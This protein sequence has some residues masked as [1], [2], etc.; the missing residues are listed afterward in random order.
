MQ[1]DKLPEMWKG[2]NLAMKL[3]ISQEENLVLLCANESSQN[4]DEGE[5]MMF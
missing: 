3:W 5:W 4:R 1:D 2:I